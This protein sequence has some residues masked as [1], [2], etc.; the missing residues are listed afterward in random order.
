LSEEVAKPEHEDE[1]HDAML[2]VLELIWGQ[3]F[4]AP[5]GAGSVAKMVGGL[6]LTG[7]QVVDVGSGLGGPAFVLAEEFGANVVGVDLEAPLVERA[8]KSARERGL[9]EQVRFE[10]VEVGPLPFEA[11]SVDLVMS[12]GAYTQTQDKLGA[13]R[14]CHRVL[15]PGGSVSLYDWTRIDGTLS[16]DMQRW[17]ELEGLTYALETLD[18]YGE[19]LEQAGFVDVGVEDASAWYRHRAARE[20]KQL[21]GPLY[22]GMA[23][24]IG[25]EQ[26]DHFVENWRAMLVVCEK[27]EM[28]QGYCRGRKP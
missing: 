23:E 13:L 12:A 19:I 6:D 16:P 5:G 14:D 26:A 24:R 1:Y 4:M 8:R 25:V 21:R 2:E 3:G 15:R 28:R 11:D 20:Y 7:K 17:I 9:G 22:A 18:R 27:G 10:V